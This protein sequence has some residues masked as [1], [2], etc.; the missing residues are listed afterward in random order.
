MRVPLEV[1]LVAFLH[2]WFFLSA[3]LFHERHATQNSMRMTHPPRKAGFRSGH[4]GSSRTYR[5][6]IVVCVLTSVWAQEKSSTEWSLKS[7][8][9]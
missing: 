3:V 6:W 9:H 5:L 2:L 4:H 8:F 1:Q 7:A